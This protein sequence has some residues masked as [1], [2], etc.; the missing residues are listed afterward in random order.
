MRKLI[1]G[2]IVSGIAIY[3]LQK[4]FDISEFKRLEGKVNWWVFP[5]LILSNLWAFVPF[6]IRWFHLLEKKITFTQSFTTAIIGVGLNM[7]LPARGGD[8]VR[9]LMNKRD[10]DL[11]LTHL[12]SRIFLEKVMDLGAVV[13]I[14][15]GALFYMGLGQSKNLSLLLIS[16]LVIL[17]MLVGLILVKYFLSTLQKLLLGIFSLI[18][19]QSFYETKLDHHL[20]EF[21]EFLQGDKLIKPLAYSLPTWIFGY[22]ISYYLAGMLIGMPIRFPEAS[23]FMFLG[24]MGVAIP[25]APSGIGVFH[26]A[27]ISGFIILGRDP[28]EGLVYATVVHLTQFLITTFLACFAYLHWRFLHKKML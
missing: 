12:L 22:A 9:L 26:A 7:V 6:S 13:V 11:P 20:I 27:I 18:G 23:L 8:L 1:F 25:S 17:A 2:I 19:K 4:N 10:S 3:F 21:S 28:G 14:G 24:G 16:A 5:L 15:A